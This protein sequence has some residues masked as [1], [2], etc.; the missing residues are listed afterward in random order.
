MW[1]QEHKFALDEGGRERV[2]YI[3]SRVHGLIYGNHKISW[4][5]ACVSLPIIF[6]GIG[7]TQR[8]PSNLSSARYPSCVSV[9]FKPGRGKSG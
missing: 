9:S 6:L 8:T 7:E 5:L 1:R 3:E 2:V 4:V